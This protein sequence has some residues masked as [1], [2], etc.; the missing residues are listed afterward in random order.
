MMFK[1]L[2]PQVN[3]VYSIEVSCVRVFNLCCF[4]SSLDYCFTEGGSPYPRLSWWV[5]PRSTL[6]F[7]WAADPRSLSFN[8]RGSA[9]VP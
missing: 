5:I 2:E 1:D 3:N 4:L 9:R 6:V 8:E 7:T